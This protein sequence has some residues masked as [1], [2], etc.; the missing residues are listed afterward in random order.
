MPFKIFVLSAGSLL[1]ENVLDA[2]EGRRD[3]VFLIGADAS[4]RHPRLFRYDQIYLVPSFE[5]V[6]AFQTRI[7]E[8]LDREKP[9]LILPGR[10]HDVLFLAKLRDAIPSLAKC[11]PCGAVPLAEMM[12]DKWESFLF[13]QRHQLPFADTISTEHATS[14]EVLN[15]VRRHGFPLIAKPRQGYGTIGVRILFE[16]GQVDR[17]ASMPGMVLQPFLAAPPNLRSYLPNESE[18]WPFFYYFEETGQYAGQAILSTNGSIEGLFGS[19]NHMVIGRVEQ[20]TPCIELALTKTLS[21]FASV[22][23]KEGWCGPFNIQCRRLHDG[24]FVAFEMNGRMTGSTSARRLLGFDEIGLTAKA[25]TGVS[26]RIG[27]PV[28]PD[29]GVVFRSLK[30]DCVSPNWVSQLEQTR[31][32]SGSGEKS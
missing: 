11:I 15:F 6:D 12:S 16:Q 5:D 17:V 26:L 27:C 3:L 31:Q 13:C 23:A 30:D 18:G 29:F 1:G 20:S 2:L 9:D 4:P 24:S 22:V 25:F 7:L 14:G 32:F 8:I 19:R 28:Y 10:D 21:Q